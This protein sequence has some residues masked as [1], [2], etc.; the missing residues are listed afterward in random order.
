MATRRGAGHPHRNASLEGELQK[1]Q[2]NLGVRDS[3]RH[4]NRGS[5]GNSQA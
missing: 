3:Y 1:P 2:P 5:R 4:A